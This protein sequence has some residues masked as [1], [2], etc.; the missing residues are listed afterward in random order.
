MPYIERIQGVIRCNCKH[1]KCSPADFLNISPLL[2]LLSFLQE[3]GQCNGN[4]TGI[5]FSSYFSF[6]MVSVLVASHPMHQ[7]VY[8]VED[9]AESVLNSGWNDH[10]TG[11]CT[12]HL[13]R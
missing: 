8:H 13:Q 1:F 4:L 6:P 2:L 12:R 5:L 9:Q 7:Q 11:S 10:L 3:P